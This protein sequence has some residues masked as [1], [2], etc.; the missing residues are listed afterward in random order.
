MKEVTEVIVS[1]DL[2]ESQGNVMFFGGN[3]YRCLNSPSFYVRIPDK[4]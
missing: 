4:P 1:R 2:E 3:G